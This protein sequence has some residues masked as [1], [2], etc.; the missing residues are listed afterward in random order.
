MHSDSN[1]QRQGQLA[2]QHSALDKRDLTAGRGRA[3][4][5]RWSTAGQ[6]LPC[7]S[8]CDS[9]LGSCSP[10]HLPLW[11]TRIKKCRRLGEGGEGTSWCCRGQA[12]PHSEGA[13]P[14][15]NSSGGRGS[16]F[17]I[18]A[19]ADEMES[20]HA[21]SG[22]VAVAYLRSSSGNRVNLHAAMPHG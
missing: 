5:Q 10:G 4:F 17:S 19:I 11:G 21:R 14:F 15:P 20:L 13:A 3:N 18:S 2:T 7:S 9:V 1:N 12:R 8:W 22:F 6:V 16:I